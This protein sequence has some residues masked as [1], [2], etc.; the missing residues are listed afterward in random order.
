[1]EA[2]SIGYILFLEQLGS[3]CGSLYQF[4]MFVVVV[5]VTA[6]VVYSWKYSIQNGNVIDECMCGHEQIRCESYVSVCRGLLKISVPAFGKDNE[7]DVSE[8]KLIVTQHFKRLLSVVG[9]VVFVVDVDDGRRFL[10]WHLR[11][12]TLVIPVHPSF[13]LV[14]K[15]VVG[16]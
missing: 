5:V 11:T 9:V 6:V 8:A 4:L 3:F 13:R 16:S 14:A 15:D 7:K 10:C 1:M 2:F 12:T